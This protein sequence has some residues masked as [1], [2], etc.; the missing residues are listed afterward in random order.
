MRK[1]CKIIPLA[2]VILVALLAITFSSINIV[3]A[4]GCPSSVWVAPGL[5]LSP[6]YSTE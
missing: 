1:A 5:S 4:N 6:P 3:R 2:A